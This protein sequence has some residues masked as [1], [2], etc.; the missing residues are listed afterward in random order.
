MLGGCLHP[1]SPSES[2]RPPRPPLGC[3]P[4]VRT[5]AFP[6]TAQSP[7]RHLCQGRSSAWGHCSIHTPLFVSLTI[8][9]V[10]TNIAPFSW[11]PAG[12]TVLADIL[13]FTFFHLLV[14][15]HQVLVWALC[16]AQEPADETPLSAHLSQEQEHLQVQQPP[17]PF[18]VSSADSTFCLTSSLSMEEKQHLVEELENTKA[19]LCLVSQEL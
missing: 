13:S 14:L 16:W 18:Q 17:S 9:L 15:F 12:F 8:S 1:D 3:A 2:C 5:W 6:C 11:L 4:G 19:R 10:F 7:P